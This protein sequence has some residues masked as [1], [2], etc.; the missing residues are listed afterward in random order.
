MSTSQPRSTGVRAPAARASRT[1]V[2]RHDLL[3]PYRRLFWRVFALNAAVLALASMLAV[4]V[5]S[6]GIFSSQVALEELAIS[7]RCAS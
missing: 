7:A 6:P 4:V 1:P 3:E 5:F 2:R